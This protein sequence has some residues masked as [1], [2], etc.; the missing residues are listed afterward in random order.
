MPLPTGQWKIN[1]NGA[2]GTLSISSVD[3]A[4]NVQGTLMFPGIAS[5]PILGFW[6]EIS[7]RLMFEFSTTTTA[8]YAYTGYLSNDQYRMP[9]LIGGTIYTLTGFY[10]VYGGIANSDRFVFGWYAQIGET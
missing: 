7:A 6:D 3:T 2:I 8:G 4:G 1:A 5:T 10:E 9:G